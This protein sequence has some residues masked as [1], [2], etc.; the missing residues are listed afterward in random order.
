MKHQ[1]YEWL[2]KDNKYIYAQSWAPDHN[3]SAVINII[4]AFGEHSGRYQRWAGLFVEKGIAV[5]ASDLIGHGRS[6]GKRGYIK[7]YQVFLDQIDLQLLKSSELFP[8]IPQVLYG[9][10]MGGNLVLNYAMSKDA[11]V[12]AIIASAPLLKLVN[13]PPGYMLILSR[14]LR[15]FFPSLTV[16]AAIDNTYRTHDQS[17]NEKLS[18]DPLLHRQMSLQLFH[19]VNRYGLY[20]MR[21]I[22]KINRPLLLM[23]GNSDRWTSHE[24]T[25]ELAANTSRLTTLKIW[26]GLYHELHNEVGYMDIFNYII[27]WLSEMKIT[28]HGK[29]QNRSKNSTGRS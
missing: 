2:S 3:P 6:F 1:D 25:M 28:G 19:E 20:A 18:E 29:I 16:K 10:S 7:N 8:G 26:D 5:L 11:P 13:E 24:A 14:I 15:P 4:H 22:Y 27:D 23:H 9:H 17:I 12:S 21:N